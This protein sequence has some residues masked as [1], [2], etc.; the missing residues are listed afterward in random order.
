MFPELSASLRLSSATLAV[1]A[2]VPVLCFAVFSAAA[3]PLSR[4]FGEERVLE[5]ALAVLAVGLL[6]R[7]AAPGVML[8]PGTALA[9]GSSASVAVT[10]ASSSPRARPWSSARGTLA[11]WRRRPRSWWSR[12]PGP[13]PARWWPCRAT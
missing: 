5:G 9:A 6:L 10:T 12:P 7:G 4:R 2:S 8:F 11:S 1:L 13:V 3:A